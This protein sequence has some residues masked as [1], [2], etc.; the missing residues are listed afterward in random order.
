MKAERSDGA[1]PDPRSHGVDDSTILEHIF[2]ESPLPI[3]IYD[4]Q[5]NTRRQNDAHVSFVSALG[6]AA[7][8]G[9]YNVL[10]DA[11]AKKSGHS[12]HFYRAYAGTTLEYRFAC[13]RG[14]DA[15]ADTLHFQHLL[16]PMRAPDGAIASVVGIIADIT[17]QEE[18]ARERMRFQERLFQLQKLESLGLLAGGI[19]HDFNNL[20]VAVLGNAS[21]LLRKIGQ[22]SPLRARVIAI[23]TAARRAADVAHQ[24]LLYAGKGSAAFQELNT[25]ELVEEISDLLRVSVSKQ[26]ELKLESESDL[27]TVRGDGTQLRQVVMN[28]LTNASE[29]LG[30]R[31]GRIR[32]RMGLTEPSAEYLGR[33]FGKPDPEAKSFVYIEVEDDGCGMT[34]DV[35][36]R[37]FDPFFTTKFTGRGLG[38]SAALG[39]LR[40]HRA[41]LHVESQVGVGTTMRVLLPSS[42]RVSS[43]LNEAGREAQLVLPK[44][45]AVLVV[46]DDRLVREITRGLLEE[47]GCVVHTA[48]SGHEALQICARPPAEFGLV[49]MDVTMP[50]LDGVVTRELLR[51]R[52]PQLPVLLMSGFGPP[53]ATERGAFLSKPFTLDD[54]RGAVAAVVA[55]EQATRSV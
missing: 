16:M 6:E 37:A 33:C 21:F 52:H 48:E 28:L 53:A 50:G 11:R 9:D 36:A 8:L 27:P 24:M 43:Q 17:E 41:A 26:A 51:Q 2:Q 39:I 4:H 55:N 46:D 32:V 42:A 35:V 30:D 20:L 23:E 12:K 29:S 7:G 47:L 14:E 18:A 40:R 1:L 13:V 19:A 34:S 38:L 3:A 45:L 44:G 54:L 49:L 31:R 10:A 25:V 15:S 22:Q 5:G